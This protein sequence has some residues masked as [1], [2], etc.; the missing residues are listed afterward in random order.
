MRD[1]SIIK[2]LNTTILRGDKVGIIGPN[3]AGKTTL[4]K[5]LLGD[6]QPTSGQVRLGTKQSVAYFDQM[7]AQLDEEASVLD[8]VSQGREF[9]E[10]NGRQKHVIG[11]LQDFLFA[12]ERSRSPVKALSGGER[13]RLDYS[14]TLLLVS[15]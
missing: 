14:G 7:R 8:N 4:L 2:N 6:L 5:I 13:N 15:H 1:T 9:I 12:P 11:Y 10:I 3:G